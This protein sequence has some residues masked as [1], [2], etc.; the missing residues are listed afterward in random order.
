MNFIEGHETLSDHSY[1][2]VIMK[3]RQNHFSETFLNIETGLNRF[4]VYMLFP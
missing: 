4:N 3:L 1:D 2:Q